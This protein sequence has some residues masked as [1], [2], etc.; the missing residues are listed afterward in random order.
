M[1][2]SKAKIAFLSTYPPRECGIGTFTKSFVRIFDEFYVKDKTKIIAVSDE[3]GKYDYSSRVIFEIDQ[4]DPLS[5]VEAA[6]YINNSSIEVVSLQHEYGIFG[7]DDGKY[8]L[9]FLENVNKPVVTSFHSVLKKKMH[10]EHRY[11]L[12]QRIID[13]SDSVVV[14]T[15]NAKKILIESFGINPKKIKIV[16]HGVPNIRFDEK[17]KGKKN[18]NLKNKTV[19]STFGLINRGKGIEKVIEALPQIVNKYPD[20]VYLVIGAT[21]PVILKQEGEAYRNSLAEL[22]KKKSLE[23][24]VIFVNKYLDYEELVEYLKATDIYLAPQLDF[25][26]AFSGTVSYAMGCGDVVISSPTNYA[27]EVT[28]GNRGIVIL[29]KPKLIA[30]TINKL[31]GNPA[32]MEKIK[33]NAYQFARNMIWPRVGLEYLNVIESNLYIEKSKWKQRIPELHDKPSLK[34]L[35]KMTDD[36]GIIQHSKLSQP[37]YD[38][39][40]SL[41]DQARA[42]IACSRYLKKY[43]DADAGDMIKKYLN[44]LKKAVD[45]NN[46]VHNFIDK[47]KKYADDYASDDSIAR[48]FWSLCYLY[49]NQNPASDIKQEIKS[50]VDV[51]EKKTSNLFVKSIA[52]NLL[53]YTA[54]KNVKQ[55]TRLTDILVKRFKENSII[56]KW[57]WFEEKITYANAIIPYA[58]VKAYELTKNENYLKIALSSLSFLE[59]AY[60]YKG[61]PSP[62]GQDGWYFVNSKKAIFDQQAIEAA[63]M[64]ILYN[65]LFTLTKEHKY[66]K[67]AKEWMGWFFGNNLNEAVIYDNVSRGVFDGLTRTGVNLNQ[68]AESIVVYLMAYLSFDK[69][70]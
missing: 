17:V 44:Y 21:H 57:H 37:D 20:V 10:S 1:D 66:E 56:N 7:G 55:S 18:L 59:E 11:K 41:D 49:K 40:Y 2:R 36:F 68:G 54:L 15:N 24:H 8:I 48:A 58:L 61:I 27:S 29:P 64:V 26:Q 4:F 28:A 46:V 39:G 45:R 34:Y 31:L 65:E 19:L 53:G 25:N 6:T 5:Y 9:K 47:N 23:N 38:F 67:K 60:Y 32:N 22:V 16:P 14:M 3:L 50:L 42:M 12:T 30:S 43:K 62:V 52:Y 70:L 69:T 35:K 51:Y 13:L 33:L 63:D